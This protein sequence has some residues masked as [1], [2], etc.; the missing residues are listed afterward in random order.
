MNHPTTITRKDLI[1]LIIGTCVV[2]IVP[3]IIMQ[4]TREVSWSLLD[5]IVAGVLLF[6]AGLAY[7]LT[8]NTI[9][10][11]K[12]RLLIGGIILGVVAAIWIQLA[13]G[14]F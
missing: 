2:L 7:K 12:H 13:V 9:S 11:K 5:F 10:S 6:A 8:T 4:F 3:L 1:E 14:I